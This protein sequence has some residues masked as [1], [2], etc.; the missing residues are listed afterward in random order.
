MVRHVVTVGPTEGLDRAARLMRGRDCSCLPVVNERGGLVGILSD[1]DICMTA[2]RLDR[3]PSCL[4]VKDAMTARVFTLHA[5]DSIEEAERSMGA[6]H[7]QQFPVLGAAGELAGILSIDDLA[8]AACRE[9]GSPDPLV[10]TEAVGRT[11]GEITRPQLVE[12]L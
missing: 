6:H 7:L 1:R 3:S 9:G 10:S 11:L 2:V 8:R 5:D 4:R 12:S